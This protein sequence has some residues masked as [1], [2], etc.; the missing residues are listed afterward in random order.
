M[1]VRKI[2]FSFALIAVVF[3]GVCLPADAQSRRELDVFDLVNRERSRARLGR[4]VWDDELAK[5]ARDYS[6]QMARDGFFDHYDPEG[7]T[8]IDRAESA[9]IRN[10]STIGENLFVCENHPYFARTAIRGWLDSETHR[11]NMLDKSWTTTGIGIA[12]SRDGSIFIT[13]V[14]THE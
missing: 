3:A 1:I 12:T 10:W 6:R 8:V 11:T 2:V 14:F 13:Q 7:R 4:L 9:R 5:L